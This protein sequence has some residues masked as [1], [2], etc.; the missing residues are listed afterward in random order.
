VEARPIVGVDSFFRI[1]PIG[2]D[3]VQSVGNWS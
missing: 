1:V 2:A 3:T